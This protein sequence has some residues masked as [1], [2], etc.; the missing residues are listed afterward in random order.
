[1]KCNPVRWLLGLLPLAL[2]GWVAVQL[3]H[4]SIAADLKQRTQAAFAKENLAWSE[5]SFSGRDGILRGRAVEDTDPQR[6]V[7]IAR[8]VWGVRVAD[9]QIDLVEKAENYVW[10]ANR[11]NNRVRMRGHVPN[12]ATRKSILGVAAATFPGAEIDDR[13]TLARGVPQQDTWL[14]GVSFALRQLAGLKRGEVRLENLGLGVVGEADDQ[15][16]YRSMKTALANQLPRG[17]RLIDERVTAPVISPY[18]WT[19]RSASGQITLSGFAPNERMK[20][21]VFAAAKAAFQGAPVVDR[22]EI[23]DGAPQGWQA[24]VGQALKDLARLEEG[25]IETRDAQLTVTGLARNEEAAEAAR[26][27][28]RSGLPQSFK[29]TDQ[30]RFREPPPPAPPA[31]RVVSP[32][33]S[34]A[35]LG[36]GAIVLTGYAPNEIAR[37]SAGEAARRKFPN[38]RIDNR[39]ELA[40]GAPDVWQRCYEAGLA[41]L[42]RVATGRMQMSDRRVDV[43]GA[44]DDEALVQAV[45]NDLA[46]NAGPECQTRAALDYQAPPEPDLVWRALWNGQTVTLEGDVPSERVRAELAEQARQIYTGAQVVDR[47][48]IVSSRSRV[49]PVVADQGLRLLARLERG[50]ARLDKQLLTIAGDARDAG[51]AADVRARLG[52]DL[53]AGY[54]GRDIIEVRA[55]PPPAPPPAPAPAPRQTEADACQSALKAA[56]S[57]GMIR[58]ERASAVIDQESNDTLNKLASVAKT[59]P[60]VTIEIEG[61][62]DSEGTPERNQRLS[63][64]RA[65][66]VVSY[67]ARAGVDAAR[68]VAIGYGETRPI[69]PNDTADNRARNRRIEFTVKTR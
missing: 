44:T 32:Y 1:M 63:D 12:E 21:E 8:S 4:Q 28:L 58:F 39:L 45:G 40:D 10:S 42:A 3:N 18:V 37:T 24:A 67:L 14:A 23:A 69:V 35:A 62:T 22:M 46:S 29:L 33:T 25:S 5:A 19:A 49:W 27:G 6:A 36:D 17:L 38:R 56:A 57:E 34:A 16:A 26:R 60:N 68:L 41:A 2:L 30:I 52:R 66:A 9:S 54:R 11:Q 50:E 48:R 51:T 65:Q 7:Q 64:R 20:D 15:N 55:A 13:L 59:C 61:H 47:M 31:A 43:T 53:S